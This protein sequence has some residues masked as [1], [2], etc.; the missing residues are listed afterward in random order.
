MSVN[1]SVISQ[2]GY[3]S[4]YLFICLSLTLSDCLTVSLSLSIFLSLYQSFFLSLYLSLSLSLSLCV[5][6][7]ACLSLTSCLCVSVCLSPCVFLHVCLC[8]FVCSLY[9]LSFCLSVQ[10]CLSVFICLCFYLFPRL[11]QNLTLSKTSESSF[12][13]WGK[14]AVTERSCSPRY[15]ARDWMRSPA[16][17]RSSVSIVNWFIVC[18]C[19]CLCQLPPC[20][21]TWLKLQQIVRPDYCIHLTPSSSLYGGHTTQLTTFHRLMCWAT[22]MHVLDAVCRVVSGG[23]F[24]EDTDVQ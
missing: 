18:V 10:V 19:V 7:S 20:S 8:L 12:I 21:S 13:C 9:L 24:G 11:A 6:L 4:V 22:L 3:L 2:P 17:S 23:E 14:E 15:E 5:F 1:L 16:R